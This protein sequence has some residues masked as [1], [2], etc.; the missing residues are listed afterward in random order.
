MQFSMVSTM[1][2]ASMVKVL[3]K[4]IA[5]SRQLGDMTRIAGLYMRT[6]RGL[7][8][9]VAWVSCLLIPYAGD[10]LGWTVGVEFSGAAACMMLM[11]LY[12]VHQAVGQ[13]Q[14]TLFYATEDTRTYMTIALWTMAF[15]IPVTYVLLAP[16]SAWLPGL[17]LGATGLA[18][19]MVVLNIAGVSVQGHVIR[20]RR[21][22]SAGFPFQAAALGFLLLV[23]WASRSVAGATARLLSEA[24]P[25]ALTVA[26][27]VLL[28]AVVTLFCAWRYPALAGVDQLFPRVAPPPATC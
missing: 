9:A 26:T 3:W 7:Y 5:E 11:L 21:G 27:G 20:R 2:T 22:W 18:V 6:M 4:E 28:Y 13:V 25:A 15:S 10:I 16:R 12:P 1:L 24:H 19:K 17:A 23:G 14:G 8:V